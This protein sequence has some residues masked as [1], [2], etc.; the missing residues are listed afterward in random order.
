MGLVEF[1]CV[2]RVKTWPS[3]NGVVKKS[4]ATCGKTRETYQQGTGV[5]DVE[6]IRNL[7]RDWRR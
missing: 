7:G 4:S 5:L 1:L 2:G 6:Y 3:R